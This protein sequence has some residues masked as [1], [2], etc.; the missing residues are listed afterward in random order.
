MKYLYL[1]IATLFSVQS[2]GQNLVLNPSFESYSSCPLGPSELENANNWHHPFNNV[3][4]DT[5][6]T[7]DLYNT[8]S[9]FGALGVGVPD[10]I[11]GSEPAHTGNGYAGIIAYEGFALIGCTALGGSSW[12]EY[13]MGELSS[14]LQAGQEYCVSFY[15]SLADN[16]KWATDDIAIYFS[17]SLLSI[18]CS[19]VSNSVLPYTPQLEYTGPDLDNANGWTELSWTYTATGGEAYFTIGNFKNDANTTYSCANSGAFNP[20][21]YYYIDDVSVEPGPC[22]APCNLDVSI[23]STQHDC[24]LGGTASLTAIASNGSGNYG[25]SWTGLGSAQTENNL[26]DGTYEVT[27]TDL[28]TV[29]CSAT[30]TITIDILDPVTAEAGP[31]DTICKGDGGSLTATGGGTYSWDVG[32][33]GAELNVAPGATTTYEVTVTG[34]NGCTDTDQA[35]IVVYQIP[36]VSFNMGDQTLCE[37]GGTLTLSAAPSGGTF[38]GAGVSGSSFNP[39]SAGLGTHAV[40]YDFAEYEDCIASDTIHITVDLCTGVETPALAELVSVY[41]NPASSEI[42]IESNFNRSLPITL[43]MMDVLGQ[44]VLN[45]IK[46]NLLGMQRKIDVSRLSRG[47]YFLRLSDGKQVTNVKILVE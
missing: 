3:I 13:A 15:I 46:S 43:E 18:N 42:I 10:N 9:P 26:G 23:Q 31:N 1:L 44:L 22:S 19:S 25:Y 30:E 16:V 6:S 40:W 28:S 35:T 2:F 33:T 29:G 5:C 7:S 24:V 21:A 14:P 37:N 34:S 11:L 38:Y 27:V 39:A 32:Q 47:I 41:P 12:R 36:K 4:G 45:P 20:Y 17:N 8:C